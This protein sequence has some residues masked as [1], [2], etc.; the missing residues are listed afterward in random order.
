VGF[1][2]NHLSPIHFFPGYLRLLT[3]SLIW[4]G[5]FPPLFDNGPSKLHAIFFLA[6]LVSSNTGPLVFVLANAAAPA[7]GLAAKDGH[8][9]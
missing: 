5:K 9:P 7:R 6:W 1:A 8:A 3:E 4:Q 2:I